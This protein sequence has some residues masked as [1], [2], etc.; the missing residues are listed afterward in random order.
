MVFT[1]HSNGNLSGTFWS[2]N[3]C[4]HNMP[5]NCFHLKEKHVAFALSSCIFWINVAHNTS[6][7]ADALMWF[8]RMSIHNGFILL[9]LQ[10]L[11]LNLFTTKKVSVLLF[12][13][14]Y[15]RIIFMI[16]CDASCLVSD[17]LLQTNEKQLLHLLQKALWQL[18]QSVLISASNFLTHSMKW[19]ILS[20]CL[21]FW[22]GCYY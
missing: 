3:D 13:S 8:I 16:C 1:F 11:S 22:M 10:K 9:L 21:V 17:N 19:K 2:I 14:Y 12:R 4:G 6:L 15:A 18:L 7:F 20:F 5:F